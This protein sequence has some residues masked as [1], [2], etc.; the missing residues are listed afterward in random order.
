M[1]SPNFLPRAAHQPCIRTG[2]AAEPADDL[3]R[4]DGLER[5]FKDHG[6]AEGKRQDAQRQQ[7]LD[8]QHSPRIPRTCNG[9]Q[10]HLPRNRDH[11][12]QRHH[13]QCVDGPLQ[14]ADVGGKQRERCLR[15]QKY[16]E[17]ERREG[18]CRAEHRAP[19]YRKDPFNLILADQVAH[20]RQSR[21]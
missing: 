9:A 8:D 11:D 4:A 17:K 14:E 13:S 16:E 19:D 3:R 20:Q 6:R 21:F 10:H 15:T 12:G 18:D 7:K 5:K 1:S 2:C